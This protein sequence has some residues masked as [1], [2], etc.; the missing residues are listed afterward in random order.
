MAE[1][2]GYPATASQVRELI[3]TLA[4]MRLA[5]A[6]TRKAERFQRLELEDPD[7]EDAK[8]RRLRLEDDA[9]QVLADVI[10][11][12]SLSR[13]TAGSEGG[14]YLRLPGEEQAWLASGR[15]EL[16]ADLLD[17]LQKDVVHIAEDRVRE[18]VVTPPEGESYTISR[19]A[20]GEDLTL[21]PLPEGR[22]PRVSEV[23]RLGAGLTYVGF[24]DLMPAAD[25][26][27]SGGM[28]V[29]TVTSFDGLEV[30][31]EIDTGEEGGW[32]TF[33]AAYVGAAEDE[34]DAAK[35]ARA[36]AAKINRRV[37]GWAYKLQ[38]YVIG[39]LTM[40]LE[41]L[42]EKPEKTS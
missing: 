31:A 38:N 25:L 27:R 5:R 16:K 28:H 20:K 39:R 21:A 2:S 9:G 1:K 24:D 33:E 36:E 8:S 15:L 10:V 12:K 6:M 13:F 34:S 22:S 4:D 14:T 42:L 3:V 41:R 11:G 40:T 35:L 29:V 7:A 26:E 19:V 18:V 32:A 30:T 17:W 23:N 37:D